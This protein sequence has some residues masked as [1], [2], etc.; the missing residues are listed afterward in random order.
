MH[1]VHV[2]FRPHA[3]ETVEELLRG[4]EPA[5]RLAVHQ[6]ARPRVRVTVLRTFPRDADLEEAGVSYRLRADRTSRFGS[7]ALVRL[8]A[9]L[10]PDVVH[11]T[12]LDSP[13]ALAELRARLPRRTVLV[14]QHRGEALGAALSRLAQKACLRAADALFFPSAAAAEPWRDEGLIGDQTVLEMLG[15]SCDLSP[16]PRVD[17]RALS[18]LEGWPA[19]LF[20]TR[21]HTPDDA[22]TALAAFE[23]AAARLP[24][25]RLHVLLSEGDVPRRVLEGRVRASP[26]LAARARLD[27]DVPKDALAAWLSSSDLFLVASA[28]AAPLA[29]VE[30]MACGAPAVASDLAAHRR[31]AADVVRL[32]PAGNAPA[33]GE[34]IRNAVR[35]PPSRAAVR[36]HFEANLSWDA[37]ARQSLGAYRTLL[38]H[39]S[40]L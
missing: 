40:R 30:A 21:F 36:A 28:R 38:G 31:L 37:I 32:F 34:A 19:V 18:R 4:E 8:A 7:R 3:F 12:G 39:R 1:V 10:R 14:A 26:L 6:A 22:L 15:A 29:L 11:V 35:T 27:G 5:I 23:N 25:A 33:A 9:E 20:S 24:D 13:L 16:V 2:G 17:A